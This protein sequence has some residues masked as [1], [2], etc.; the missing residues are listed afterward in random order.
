MIVLYPVGIPMVYAALL[1]VNRKAVTDRINRET[2]SRV[3]SICPLWKPYKPER[4][5]YEVVECGRRILLTGVVVFI[6][7][8]SA[9]Q[10]A[11]TIL[12]EVFF[13]FVSELLAPYAVKWDAWISRIGHTV[14][15]LSMYLALL[16]KV[17]VSKERDHSQKV[18]EA[19]L[20]SIHICLVVAV[21]F[22][23]I[24]LTWSL[25]PEQRED[26][27]PRRRG[28]RRSCN[29][30]VSDTENGGGNL[31]GDESPERS[32]QQR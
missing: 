28:I 20:V 32:D 23:A 27:I 17:D 10:V 3:K 11:I 24:A 7:P 19:I 2:S 5:Y 14:V 13:A 16:L 31:D 6:F 4:F 21:V 18:F 15:F 9:A 22:E 25:K 26:P 30:Q 1:F 8:N 29:Q 12:I